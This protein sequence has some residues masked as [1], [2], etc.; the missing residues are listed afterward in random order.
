MGQRKRQQQHASVQNLRHLNWLD[1]RS[2]WTS[3]ALSPGD[4]RNKMPSE[5]PETDLRSIS[6]VDWHP[7]DAHRC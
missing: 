1:R 5:Q 7:S 2:R 3:M 6:F 4:R